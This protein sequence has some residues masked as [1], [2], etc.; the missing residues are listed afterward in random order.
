MNTVV[1]SGGVVLTHEQF[2]RFR[3]LVRRHAGIA[4]RDEKKQLVCSRLS[5]RLRA[6]QI[7]SFDEYY[8]LVEAEDP[9]GDE[10]Q[11]LLNA[12]TTNKTNFFRESHHFEVMSEELHT[13]SEKGQSTL[14]VWSAGSSTGEEAYTILMTITEALPGW[15]SIDVRV[16]ASDIDTNVL[17]VGER[18]VYDQRCLDDVPPQLAERWLIRGTGDK[19]GLVRVRRELRQR[20]AF[21]QINFVAETWPVR[22]TFDV[23][24]CRNAL[25]YFD[26]PTQNRIVDRLLRH[27]RPGGLLFLGHAESMAGARADLANL[28]RTSY[29]YTGRS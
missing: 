28:G 12:I 7:E 22:A 18:A 2:E 13:W 16:L 20:A 5:K 19:A 29:R 9:Q 15:E 26:Q 27:L 6:L 14:R 8:T 23:I 17:A 3:A 1:E 11:K 25:I 21:R 10:L 4:L 24:F